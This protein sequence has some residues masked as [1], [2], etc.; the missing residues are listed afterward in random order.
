MNVMSVTDMIEGFQAILPDHLSI[1]ITDGDKYMYYRPSKTIDLKIEPGDLIK[2]D[3]VTHKALT[4][5]KKTAEYVSAQ[6]L[7]VPYYG[8]STPLF[9]DHRLIGCI[10]LISESVQSHY[11]SNFLTVMNQNCWYPVPHD[12]ITVIEANSRR[13][14]VHTRSRVGTNKFNLSQLEAILPHDTFYRCHRSY[15]INILQIKEIQPESH[16]TFTLIMNDD[17]VV[18]VSQSYASHFR[19][20]LAF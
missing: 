2:E 5:K 20:M 19:E 9:S 6:V 12:D 10:T 16:S 18:P 15:L 17:T 3:T 1:A 11:Q 14:W 4:I 8:I 13:T 7:G